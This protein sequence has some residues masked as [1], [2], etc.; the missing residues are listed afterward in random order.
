MSELEFDRAKALGDKILEL[1]RRELC[2]LASKLCAEIKQ[3]RGIRAYRGGI[4]P[5]NICLE[6]G[7]VAIGPAKTSDW[8]PEELRFLPPEQFWNGRTGSFSDVYSIGMLLWYGLSRGKFPFEGQSRDPDKRRM[9][10]ENFPAPPAAG[11]R[12]GEI[13]QRATRFNADERYGNV[14]QLQIMLDSWLDNRYLNGVDGS[15]AIFHK[16]SGELTEIEKIMVDI[17]ENG[18]EE[19]ELAAEGAEPVELEEEPPEQIRLYEP[20][21]SRQAPPLRQPIP[22]LTEEKNPELEPVAPER[23]PIT[24]AVQY[25]KSAIRERK[26]A[27]EARKRRRHPGVA[28]LVLCAFLV[29]GAIVLNAMLND[30]VWNSGEQASPAPV[31]TPAGPAPTPAPPPTAAPA[32]KPESRYEFYKE[33][34]SWTEA[35][36]RCVALG[37]HLAVIS[38][39]NEYDTVVRAAQNNSNVKH[40]WIGLHREGNAQ[41]WETNEDV[42]FYAWDVGAGEPSFFDSY[43]N[44]PENYVMLWNNNGGW[45]YNDSRDDP[46]ADYP[47]IYGDTM[48]FICEFEGE[49][50]TQEDEGEP[51]SADSVAPGE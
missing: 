19:P 23:R 49:E 18:A 28:V 33:D 35:R 47:D 20:S 45:Y 22:I 51:E 11:E 41:I 38:D 42:N 44:A 37:G 4:Y 46:A 25:G 34:L 43:D 14:E 24:P 48:G 40:F 50:Q 8:G 3:E 13:I 27:E 29:V 21:H 39:Q 2:R 7:A 12:L 10:G 30:V 17:I 26:I 9:D 16:G 15:K 32:D 5:G 36:D 1:D 31:Y 6:N